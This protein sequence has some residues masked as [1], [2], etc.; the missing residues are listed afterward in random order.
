MY[1]KN[2]QE[3]NNCI[4]LKQLSENSYSY[5]LGTVVTKSELSWNSSKLKAHF[6]GATMK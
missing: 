1:P 2:Y 6:F 3:V 4:C 5:I